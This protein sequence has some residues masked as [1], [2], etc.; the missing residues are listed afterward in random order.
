MQAT[1]SELMDRMA[2]EEHARAALEQEVRCV[3]EGTDVLHARLDA[4]SSA[5]RN[6]SDPRRRL[7]GEG[8]PDGEAEREKEVRSS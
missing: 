4:R 6:C 5:T 3:E 2:N 7:R 8:Q 1:V